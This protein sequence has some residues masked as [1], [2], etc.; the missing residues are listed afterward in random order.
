MAFIRNRQ[1]QALFE[2]DEALA[3][4][5]VE[6]DQWDLDVAEAVAAPVVAPAPV[7]HPRKRAPRKA[8]PVTEE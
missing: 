2:V 3:Q 7:A 6:T 8:A 1:T 4:R 5:L